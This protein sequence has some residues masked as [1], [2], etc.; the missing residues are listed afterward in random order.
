MIRNFADYWDVD[1][2]AGLADLCGVEVLSPDQEHAVEVLHKEPTAGLMGGVNTGKS[3]LLGR[4]ALLYIGCHGNCKA[5]FS[6][7]QEAQT[8]LLS[9]AHLCAGYRFANEKAEKVGAPRQFGGKLNKTDW[10]CSTLLPDWWARIHACQRGTDGSSMKGMLHAPFAL[11]CLEEVNGMDETG[12]K[13]LWAGTRAPGARF[14]FSFNPVSKQDT[15]GHLWSDLPSAGQVQLSLLRFVEWQERMGLTFE[16]C[17]D[18]ATLE[19]DFR[20]YEGTPLWYTN[21]LGEFPPDDASWVVVPKT[22]FDICAHS[23]PLGASGTGIGVDTAGGRAENIIAVVENGRVKIAWASREL[24][25]TPNIVAAVKEVARNYPRG[26]PIAVDIVGQGGKGVADDL[27][28]DGYNALDFRGG[29]PEFNGQ[30]DPDKLCS[31]SI[32]WAWFMVRRACESTIAGKPCIQLPQDDILRE[33][34]ARRYAASGEKKWVMASKDV[35][36]KTLNLPKLRVSPDRADAV[37]MAWAAAV[38]GQSYTPR[39]L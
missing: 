33:Q 9:W 10:T 25:Q 14:W 28:A 20:K 18:R 30:S 16:G 5:I 34:F 36:H 35:E 23:E 19:R 12:V 6:G 13:A 2:R 38:A 22:W 24:H 21:V 17:T 27:R 4:L 39:W 31:E 26:T 37:A 32:T 3:W 1:P 8:A 29:D 7:P 15:A 11:A